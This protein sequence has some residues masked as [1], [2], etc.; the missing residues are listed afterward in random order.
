[1]ATVCPIC[2]GTLSVEVLVDVLIRWK[3]TCVECGFVS[4]SHELTTQM[5]QSLE[6]AVVHGKALPPIVELANAVIGAKEKGP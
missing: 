6:L 2:Q 1:M 3:R 5:Q 4:K